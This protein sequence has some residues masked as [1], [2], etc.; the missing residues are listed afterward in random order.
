MR[1]A[2]SERLSARDPQTGSVTAEVA[3]TFPVVVLA[4]AVVLLAGSVA[5]AGVAC[6]DAARAAGRAL[7]RGETVAVATA[8]AAQ[9]A[10]RPLAVQVA[11]SGGGIVEVTARVDAVPALVPTWVDPTAWRL[12]VTCRARAWQE[13]GT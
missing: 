3:I 6:A 2:R 12:P 9:V 8:T 1:S 4:L 11:P 5:Q 10:G 13:P 7:A